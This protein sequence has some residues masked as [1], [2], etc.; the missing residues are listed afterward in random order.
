MEHNEK[1]NFLANSIKNARKVMEKVESGVVNTNNSV[2]PNNVLTEDD[3]D[4]LLDPN[5][6][7]M[8]SEAQ[9]LKQKNNS[10]KNISKSKMPEAILKSFQENPI[11][12]P[13]APIGM[14]SMMQEIV[15]KAAPTPRVEPQER[16]FIAESKNTTQPIDTK[17]IEFIIKKTVDE[18]FEQIGKKTSIDED[19]QIKI[20]GKTFGG[21]LKSMNEIKKK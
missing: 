12:D 4:K 16:G 17:L 11:V 6:D 5:N 13:T 15:K 10:M 20:G 1:L 14:E 2:R 19:F 8:I 3:I 21:K 7:E 9:M 18:V